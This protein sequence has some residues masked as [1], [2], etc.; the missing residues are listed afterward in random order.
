MNG[1]EEF[2]RICTENKV[3]F[4]KPYNK[5]ARQQAGFSGDWI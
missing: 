5:V 2:K 1:I 4:Y 3:K